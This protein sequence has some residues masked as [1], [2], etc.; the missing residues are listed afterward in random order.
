[1]KPEEQEGDEETENGTPEV[2]AKKSKKVKV[3]AKKSAK[4]MRKA[5]KK[6][7]KKSE[8]KHKSKKVVVVKKTEIKEVKK[9]SNLRK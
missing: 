6:A 1:M 3:S 9:K 7:E 2:E 5:E 8:K 4:S